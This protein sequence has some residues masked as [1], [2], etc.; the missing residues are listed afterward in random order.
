MK[1]MRLAVLAM[2]TVLVGCSSSPRSQDMVRRSTAAVTR[3][4]ASDV[5][6]AAL[7]IRDGLKHDAKDDAVD[8]NGASR[9]RLEAL[10]GIS[11]AEAQRIIDGRPYKT[12]GDLVRRHVLSKTEYGKIESR[13]VAR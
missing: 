1:R 3:T 6:G 2:G 4:V 9:E 7:G 13:V 11:G 5:K 10:P 12:P 8:V